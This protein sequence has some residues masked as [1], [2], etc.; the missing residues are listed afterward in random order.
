MESKVS[1]VGYEISPD[2]FELCKQRKTDRL[3]YKLADIH[4][5]SSV[6]YDVVMAIDVIEHVEDYFGFLRSLKE[7]GEY[8]IFHIPLDMTVQA[9]L[10]MSP[11]LYARK[12]VGHIHYFSKETALETLKDTGYEI[13]DWF[14]TFASIELKN[15]PFMWRLLKL[16]LKIGYKINLKLTTRIAGG[17]SLM[18]LA[19]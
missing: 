4:E 11:I 13:L 6:Y 12:K 7:K 19:K 17:C 18:V 2:A 9:V 5:D 8:K 16:P 1:F 15:L 3:D 14:Y 10:R